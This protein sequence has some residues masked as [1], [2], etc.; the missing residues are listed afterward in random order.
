[1]AIFM[2]GTPAGAP[3][4]G[5]ISEQ[6]GPRWTIGVGSV[7]VALALVGVSF[8]LARSENVRVSYESQRRPR[9][10]VSTTP[11]PDDERPTVP[12]LGAVR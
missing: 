4:I 11:V 12:V 10:T 3:M 9:I 6:L 7:A 2:G 8:W 1:M 5:W